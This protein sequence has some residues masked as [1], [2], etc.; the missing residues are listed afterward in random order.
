VS[1]QVQGIHIH[2]HIHIHID[3]AIDVLL[4]CEIPLPRMLCWL[5][6]AL[7]LTIFLCCFVTHRSSSYDPFLDLSVPIYRE[8]EN[9]KNT[10]L[11]AIRNSTVG[12]GDSSNKS[13]LEKCLEKFTGRKNKI[14]TT[15]SPKCR[16]SLVISC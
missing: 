1:H 3:T 8:S 14:K 4:V 9:A 7:L 11:G 6:V 5:I 15:C 16:F 13:T 2:I 10:F 12:G